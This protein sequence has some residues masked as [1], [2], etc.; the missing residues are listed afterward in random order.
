MRISAS[1]AL[2]A[3]LSA[4]ASRHPLDQGCLSCRNRLDPRCGST[5]CCALLVDELLLCLGR[6]RGP[7]IGSAPHHQG[8]PAMGGGGAAPV[9]DQKCQDPDLNGVV[10]GVRPP[11][12]PYLV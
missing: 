12:A 4:A 1:F 3:L 8:T 6:R 5:P 9:S 7:F 11:K 10:C 2:F